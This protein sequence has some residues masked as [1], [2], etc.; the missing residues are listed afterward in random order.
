MFCLKDI[1]IHKFQDIFHEYFF[2]ITFKLIFCTETFLCNWET[3]SNVPI[4]I[5]IGSNLPCKKST[6]QIGTQ[7]EATRWSEKGK[8]IEWI[9][10]ENLKDLRV[11]LLFVW[12]DCQESVTGLSCRSHEEAC[13]REKSPDCF[14]NVY[15]FW[16]QT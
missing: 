14:R 8:Y 16:V 11:R 10:C 12:W 6:L 7:R 15:D 1:A 13:F 3:V 2:K 4:R 5:Q 9:L